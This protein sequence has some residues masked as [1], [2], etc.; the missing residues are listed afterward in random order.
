MQRG[1]VRIEHREPTFHYTA[2]FVGQG[3][4]VHVEYELP[5]DGRDS[6]STQPGITIVSS[7]RW[8]GDALVGTWRIQRPDGETT[9][10]FRHELL[11][12]GRR[13]RATERL[14]GSGQDQ[15]N[16]WMFERR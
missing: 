1:V 14:R 10:S 9:I 7:L 12:A 3:G 8:E 4:P 13:L 16:V 2:A 6:V 11:D 5:S 15:D